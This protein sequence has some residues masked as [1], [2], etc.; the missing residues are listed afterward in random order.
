MLEKST[1]STITVA[2]AVAE[3]P[4]VIEAVAQAAERGMAKF[5]LFGDIKVLSSI[6]RE[7]STWLMDSDTIRLSHAVD[8]KESL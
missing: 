2:I 6:V 3:D 5:I 7:Y 4:E 8:S 1:S